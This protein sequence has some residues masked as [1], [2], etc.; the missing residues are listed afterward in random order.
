[1]NLSICKQCGYHKNECSC[2]DVDHGTSEQVKEI[3]RI[4]DVEHPE[5]TRFFDP[6]ELL[7]EERRIEI[8]ETKEEKPKID[9]VK[10]EPIIT[11][12]CTTLRYNKKKVEEMAIKILTSNPDIPD[13]QLA[14]EIIRQIRG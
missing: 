4:M 8:V 11:G 12:I 5:K 6:D 14:T 1:M 13:N 2:N 9:I 3:L 7:H 10:F